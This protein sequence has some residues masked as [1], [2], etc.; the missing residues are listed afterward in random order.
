LLKQER[1]EEGLKELT[2]CTG[3]SGVDSSLESEA[4]KM[5]AAPIRARAPFAPDFSFTT[6][7]NMPISNVGLRGKVV[8]LDFWGTWCPPC[9][10]SVPIL[11]NLNKKYASK[12]FQLVGVSSD[13]DEDVWRTFTEAQKMDWQQYIDLSGKVLEAFKIESFPTYIVLDKDGV[14]RFRQSGLGPTTESD[15]EEAISKALKKESDPKLAALSANAEPA[16][17]VSAARNATPADS[18]SPAAVAAGREKESVDAD[19]SALE[20]VEAATISGGVYRNEELGMIYEL[21]KNWIA[22][23]PSATHALNEKNDD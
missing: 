6:R 12:P 1:D 8:L 9:R 14:I 21:P 20:G 23:K 4:R 7:Q 19:G 5:I 10:E 11:R 15:V 2:A 3:M 22:A 17:V 13:D 18:R 16:A